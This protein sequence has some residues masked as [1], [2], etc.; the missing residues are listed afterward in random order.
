[1]EY[2]HNICLRVMFKLLTLWFSATY[3]GQDWNIHHHLDTFNR[4]MTEFKAP[5]FIPRMPRSYA[6]IK[7]WKASEF[8]TFLLYLGPIIL[9]DLLREPYYS[10]FLL[11]SAGCILL[12]GHKISPENLEAAGVDL[13]MFLELMEEFYGIRWCSKT[14][15]SVKHFIDDVL[16]FGPLWVYSTFP[17][18][19]YYH[20]IRQ[21]IHGTNHV[22]HQLRH[23]AYVLRQTRVLSVHLNQAQ[24]AYVRAIGS[25]TTTG[26][27]DVRRRPNSVFV[28]PINDDIS[29]I[30]RSKRSLLPN[31][32]RN[33]VLGAAGLGNGASIRSYN[34]LWINEETLHGTSYQRTKK[35]CNHMVAYRANNESLQFF[36]C[37]SF[38]VVRM[39]AQVRVIVL[40]KSFQ[41]VP[42]N[43]CNPSP[44]IGLTADDIEIIN[45]SFHEVIPLLPEHNYTT[46]NA[47]S[48]IGMAGYLHDQVLG[49]AF[50]FIRHNKLIDEE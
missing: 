15:H 30:G 40:G 6:D 9:R 13:Q 49:R 45:D 20:I 17:F 26:F 29:A 31:Q 8:R 39:G 36:T 18:E 1:M 46:I 37:N 43:F 44:Q 11:L 34:R 48:I 2:Q 41:L 32:F 12:L 27:Y 23:G 50:T 4:R 21:M 47:N 33:L 25:Q 19:S 28:T 14:V 42:G 10:H 24:L 7:H 5:V 35:R 22:L 38:H 3:V 16:R